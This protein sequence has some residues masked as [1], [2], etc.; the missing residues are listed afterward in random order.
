MNALFQSRPLLLKLET[1]FIF[2]LGLAICLSK[3]L[4]YLSTL[5]LMGVL[6]VRLLADPEYRQSLFN[7]RLFWASVGVFVLGVVSAAIGSSHPDD[8]GWMAKKTLLLVLLVP[9]LLAFEHKTNRVAALTGVLLGFWIAFVLTGNLYEWRW[10]GNRYEGA[11]WMVDTWGV[12]CAM[13]ILCLTPLVFVFAS[14][15]KWRAV[16]MVTLVGAMLMLVT[17][18]AR[19]PWLGVAAGGV[20]Y[21]AIKQRRALLVVGAIGVAALFVANSLWPQ[22][23]SA[24]Q[25]RAQSIANTQTDMSNVIRL[26]LWETG[27]ALITKQLVT[28][29]KGFWFGNGHEGKAALAN[30]FYYNEFKDKA[31]FK[32]GVLADI[33][34]QVDDLHSMYFVSVFQN[35]MLW[36]V[37]SLT[38]LLWLGL[39]PIRKGQRFTRSWLAVPSLMGFLVIGITYTLLPHFALMFLIYFMTLARGFESSM[40]QLS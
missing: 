30:D 37:G 40:D 23:I 6:A 20:L 11:T 33:G 27:A 8:V 12:L 22:Q 29:D 14:Q 36:T 38:V 13:L 31:T 39:G 10:S 28:G 17:T 9:L 16:L 15:W 2:L 1:G 4:I 5:L 35:G 19:G 3:P 32:P 18:G 34:W 7:N 25:S 24:F 21:L 26:A